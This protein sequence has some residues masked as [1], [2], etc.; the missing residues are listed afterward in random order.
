LTRWLSLTV[1]SQGDILPAG[2]WDRVGAAARGPDRDG[3]AQV[4]E[5]Q[6]GPSGRKYRLVWRHR[7][8]LWLVLLA[9]CLACLTLFAAANFA[10]VELRLIFWEGEVRVSWIGLGALA[11]GFGLGLISAHLVRGVRAVLRSR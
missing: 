7:W 11:L 3:G 1:R 2:I 10:H 6:A 9:A 4:A 5:E 8:T